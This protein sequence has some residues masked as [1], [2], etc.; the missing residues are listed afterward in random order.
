M[1][2]I[3]LLET[4]V[5]T[6]TLYDIDD[7]RKYKFLAMELLFEGQFVAQI[8]IKVN[9]YL[10]LRCVSGYVDSTEYIALGRVLF[11]STTSVYAWIPSQV[12][13]NQVYIRLRGII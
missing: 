12:N 3:T 5:N 7:L 4:N 1:K 8:I 13:V 11:R 10:T 2:W 9:D 6:Q